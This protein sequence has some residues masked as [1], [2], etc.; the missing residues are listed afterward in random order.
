MFSFIRV[1]IE[2]L[3]HI[4]WLCYNWN[5][6]KFEEQIDKN[7]FFD[8]F[9]YKHTKTGKFRYNKFVEKFL[10]KEIDKNNL[11]KDLF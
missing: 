9:L 3:F 10:D 11:K 1:H 5:E 7:N 8:S 2:N 6:I 4:L